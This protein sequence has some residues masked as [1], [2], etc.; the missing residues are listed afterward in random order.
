VSHLVP[1]DWGVV[2]I[3]FSPTAVGV[4][5]G[6]ITVHA[7]GAVN[8]TRTVTATARGCDPATDQHCSR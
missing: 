7:A 4:Y 5:D 1:A 8:N 6:T 2:Y 3:G